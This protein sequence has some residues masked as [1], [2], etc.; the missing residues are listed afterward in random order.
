MYDRLPFDDAKTV[1]SN[2]EGVLRRMKAPEDRAIVEA[3][4]ASLEGRP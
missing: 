4:L 2:K 1:A 3:W